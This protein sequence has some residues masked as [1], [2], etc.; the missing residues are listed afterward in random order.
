M[1]WFVGEMCLWMSMQI[2][3]LRSEKQKE[4]N[5]SNKARK[6]LEKAKAEEQAKMEEMK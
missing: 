4:E 2:D 5:A 3:K 1:I 6:D